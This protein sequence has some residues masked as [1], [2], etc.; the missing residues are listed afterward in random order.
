[1]K[2][3]AARLA[4][5]VRC[6]AILLVAQVSLKTHAAPPPA[7]IVSVDFGYNGIMPFERWGP[8]RVTVTANTGAFTGTVE[9]RYR[10]DIL[11]SQVISVPASA[12]AGTSVPVEAVVNFPHKVDD[13]TVT[14][15][16]SGERPIDRAKFGQPSGADDQVT[17]PLSLD[18]GEGLIGCVGKVS[19]VDALR[20]R[21]HGVPAE[22]FSYSY[23]ALVPRNAAEME[24]IRRKRSARL[25][26]VAVKPEALSTSW[27]AF[28]SLEAL[29][30]RT[31]E[32]SDR[33]SDDS[34]NAILQWVQGGGRLIL[35]VDQIGEAWSQWVGP[36]LAKQIKISDQA[37]INVPQELGR[38]LKAPVLVD[39][40]S[41]P[42]A[43]TVQPGQV[44]GVPPKPDDDVEIVDPAKKIP[45][46][47]REKL[48]PATTMSA[49]SIEISNALRDQGWAASWAVDG[50]SLIA[51][52]PVG[53]GTITIVGFDPAFAAA[54]PN[55]EASYR[56]WLSVLQGPL[57]DWVSCHD[58][59]DSTRSFYWQRLGNSGA[60]EFQRRAIWVALNKVAEGPASA[61][62]PFVVIGGV[63]AV[64]LLLAVFIGPVD[65]IVL[66]LKSAR[67]VSWLTALGWIGLMTL[68]AAFAPMV[69][70]GDLKSIII[71]ERVID[72]SPGSPIWTSTATGVFASSSGFHPVHIDTPTIFLRGAS[73]SD[74]YSQTRELLA[75]VRCVQGDIIVGEK[76][77][78]S[79]I[80]SDIEQGQWAFRT[81]LEEGPAGE[82]DRIGTVV[83]AGKNDCKI[84]ITFPPGLKTIPTVRSAKLRVGTVDMDAQSVIPGTTVGEP[85]QLTFSA[86]P[87][88]APS[89]TRW[90]EFWSGVTTQVDFGQSNAWSDHMPGA[91]RRRLAIEHHLRTG[92][93]ALLTLS[94]TEPDSNVK[95]ADTD[96]QYLTG[97]TYRILIPLAAPA[98][99]P[100]S[101]ATP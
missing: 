67:Q 99:V 55:Y 77:I 48:V 58:L 49:R 69:I 75:P 33:I 82:K 90:N 24:I 3:V 47:L 31:E 85:L 7:S 71:R 26:A 34:R 46:D 38:V 19:A 83:H 94:Y 45:E 95:L 61:F 100:D 101:G 70:R 11:Q 12:A 39:T 41:N 10:Q 72:Q 65:A 42:P 52:G 74:S 54:V 93:Y 86:L 13:I 8:V 89:T 27:A 4:M 98:S 92:N 68:L 6:I 28:D 20:A 5:L 17:I 1:M 87:D 44:P 78:S 91:E 30:V 37:R 51:Q 79:T 76:R 2:A 81:L 40:L 18:Q 62:S 23:Q 15:F 32:V 36:Q 56:L 88:S 84:E 63:A 80:P 60:S 21:W 97:S 43:P 66:K 57:E 59:G 29:V 14:L 64:I 9:I 35:E 96:A 16:D 50:K 53:F 73:I 25:R 22:V